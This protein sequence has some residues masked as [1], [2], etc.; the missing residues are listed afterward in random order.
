VAFV[1]LE[2]Q[3]LTSGEQQRALCTDPVFV[4]LLLLGLVGHDIQKLP[5]KM[6]SCIS[7]LPYWVRLN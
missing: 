2:L 1:Q 6:M 5:R 3:K 4:K 7:Q